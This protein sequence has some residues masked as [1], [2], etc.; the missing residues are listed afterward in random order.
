MGRGTDDVLRTLAPANGCAIGLNG[1]HRGPLPDDSSNSISGLTI[2]VLGKLLPLAKGGVPGASMAFAEACRRRTFL[3]PRCRGGDVGLNGEG[4]AEAIPAI[5]TRADGRL[6][7]ATVAAAATGVRSPSSVRRR[8][9]RVF[10]KSEAQVI[11]DAGGAAVAARLPWVE[12]GGEGMTNVFH[13]VQYFP[14]RLSLA[15]SGGPGKAPDIVRCRM[16]E[17]TRKCALGLCARA[18]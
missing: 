13:E 8:M 6:G 3:F 2:K 5:A 7:V 12:G 14:L 9:R 1:R 16:V 18:L 10:P 11:G 4:G 17:E 15:P